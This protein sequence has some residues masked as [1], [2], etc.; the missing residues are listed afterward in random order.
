MVNHFLL[1]K[2]VKKERIP[3][4]IFVTCQPL[5]EGMTDKACDCETSNAEN[6]LPLELEDQLNAA[7]CCC[8]VTNSEAGKGRGIHG[9]ISA[10]LIPNLNSGSWKLNAMLSPNSVE[11]FLLFPARDERIIHE[12]KIKKEKTGW[13]GVIGVLSLQVYRLG[14]Q[15]PEGSSQEMEPKPPVAGRLKFGGRRGIQGDSRTRGQ[16]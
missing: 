2:G 4:K 13:E 16:E 7:M 12:E 11:L 10:C 5:R 1:R 6:P 8:N 3:V 15:R 14:G 9:K